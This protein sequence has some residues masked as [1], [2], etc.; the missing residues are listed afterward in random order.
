MGALDMAKG[1]VV[2]LVRRRCSNEVVVAYLMP[3]ALMTFCSSVEESSEN[4]L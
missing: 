4:I 1:L 3:I 2:G